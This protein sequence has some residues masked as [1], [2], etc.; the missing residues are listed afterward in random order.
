MY[1]ARLL[2]QGC[3]IYPF[4]GV[5]A[6]QFISDLNALG[7]ITHINLH[8]PGVDFRWSDP[9]LISDSKQKFET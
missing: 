1:I 2:R 7:D 8:I 9:A 6:K 3:K 4:W 5:T